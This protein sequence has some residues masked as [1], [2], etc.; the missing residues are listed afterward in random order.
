M[1]VFK[2]QEDSKVAVKSAQTYYE[3][4]ATAALMFTY[5]AAIRLA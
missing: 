2:K 3:V 5:F 4:A 1:F